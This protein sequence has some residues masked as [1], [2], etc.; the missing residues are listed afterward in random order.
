MT[1]KE[2]GM[3]IEIAEYNG[4]GTFE[5]F[6]EGELICTSRTPFLSAARILLQRGGN[7]EELALTTMGAGV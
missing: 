5:V 6:F 1:A 3:K 2:D 7:P 4:H